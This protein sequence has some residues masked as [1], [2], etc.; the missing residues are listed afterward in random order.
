LRFTTP[1]ADIARRLIDYYIQAGAFG[2][3]ELEED[4]EDL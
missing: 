4:G 3:P 2:I 1:L